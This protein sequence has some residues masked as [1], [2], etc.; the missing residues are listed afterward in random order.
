MAKISP[1]KKARHILEAAGMFGFMAVMKVIGVKRASNFCGKLARILGPK[2]PVTNRARR[3]LE[4]SFPEK[5]PEDIN[6][7]IADMW[8]NLGRTFGEYPHLDQFDAYS[9]TGRISTTGGERIDQVQKDGAGGIFFSGHFANWEVLPLSVSGRG[10]K[11]AE[12]YRAAN[13]PYVDNWILRQRT[14]N[15]F[16]TQVPKGAKGAKKLIEVMKAKQHICMLVDQKMND[17]ISVPFMGREAMTAPAAAQ[18]ALKYN[19][20]LIPVAIERTEGTHF[21][22]EVHPPV[23]FEP[24][25]RRSEDIEAL[26]TKLNEWLEQQIRKT[27]SQW[28]WLHNRWPKT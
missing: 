13:N 25:G 8:E 4:Q 15:V 21:A 11:G 5:S 2:I 1:L 23:A 20:P 17:G 7:I 27:P 22:I 3:N 14:E 24:T 12:V 26:T 10:L 28:L 6:A 16:P 18:L 9:G 19:C